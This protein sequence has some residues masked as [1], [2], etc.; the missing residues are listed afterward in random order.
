MATRPTIGQIDRL[1]D[2]VQLTRVDL[3]GDVQSVR[4]NVLRLRHIAREVY[5]ELM[6]IERDLAGPDDHHPGGEMF[7]RVAEVRESPAIR[8]NRSWNG[9]FRRKS[10][11][12]HLE[13]A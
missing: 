3:H 12:R 5:E 2:D 1:L 9:T 7:T 10:D 13:A 6:E 4:A 11:A 8:R